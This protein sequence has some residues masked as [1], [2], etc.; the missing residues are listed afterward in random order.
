MPPEAED[1]V[2]DQ[3]DTT[4]DDQDGADD[5]PPT[6]EPDE[7]TAPTTFA[8]VAAAMGW[9]PKDQFK[10]KREGDKWMPAKEFVAEF[11]ARQR[12]TMKALREHKGKLERLEPLVAQLQQKMTSGE[13]A[14]LRARAREHMEAGEY[15]KAEELFDQAAKGTVPDAPAE[16][17]ALTAFKE[18]NEWYGADEDATEYVAFL[19]AKFAKEAGGVKDP[20]AHMRR[21]EAGVKKRFPELF[22]EPKAKDEPPPRRA[23]L[24]DR[25]GR[26]ERAAPGKI[27]AAT[28]TPAQ[29]KAAETM[30]VSPKDYAEAL[31]QQN[32]AAA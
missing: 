15:D 31:N 16:H 4:L 6:E 14:E 19:D 21:V 1:Q 10:P 8:E 28:L 27:T 25:G 2:D 32:G 22:G 23:P 18:R 24:A 17:P 12:N 9:K 20:D 7:D 3:V 26:T 29:R 30:G 5:T 11:N 13:K